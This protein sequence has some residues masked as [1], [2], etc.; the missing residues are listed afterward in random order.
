MQLLAEAAVS[1]A[2]V[3][4]VL[5]V[6]PWSWCA[7]PWSWCVGPWSRWL[8]GGRFVVVG[9]GV[10]VAGGGGFVVVG[11]GVVVD[12]S[13]GFAFDAAFC[14]RRRPA[15]RHQQCGNGHANANG[16]RPHRDRT[17]TKGVGMAESG[18]GASDSLLARK[19]VEMSQNV[20][21]CPTCYKPLTVT[22]S[23]AIVTASHSA[24]RHLRSVLR[25]SGGSPKEDQSN[26]GCTT[27]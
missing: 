10:V 18:S 12:D 14:T 19:S 9:A 8:G 11:A 5:R 7:A 1:A 6:A 17:L 16:D 22:T 23:H 27:A 25:R 4:V 15:A 13:A 3:V 21:K 2:V 20:P 26:Y 24:I